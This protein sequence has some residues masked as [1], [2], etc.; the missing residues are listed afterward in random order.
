MFFV[1]FLFFFFCLI[2]TLNYTRIQRNFYIFQDVLFIITFE[3]HTLVNNSLC[4][5]PCHYQCINIV[6]RW[7]IFGRGGGS[8]GYVSMSWRTKSCKRCC[9]LGQKLF[10]QPQL[11]KK[12]D[13]GEGATGK[14][15]N[16]ER[17][18]ETMKRKNEID[19]DHKTESYLSKNRTQPEFPY[20]Q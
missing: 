18:K 1:F 15:L 2:T 8:R 13:L 11:R 5:V 17:K 9:R 3:A 6:F 20:S 7:L 19:L 14:L 10:P 16:V 12:S 4:N